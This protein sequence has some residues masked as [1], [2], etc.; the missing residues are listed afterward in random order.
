MSTNGGPRGIVL[1]ARRELA[2]GR[3]KAARRLSD[4]VPGVQISRSLTT[5]YDKICIRLFQQAL[6]D[7]GET[8]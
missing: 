3:E 4:S 2:A 8:G 1:T 6:E 7:L 5:L